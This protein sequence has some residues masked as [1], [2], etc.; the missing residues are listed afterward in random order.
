MSH[1]DMQAV[2]EEIPGKAELLALGRSMFTECDP[3]WRLEYAL[4]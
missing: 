1:R 3:P 4:R 2:E